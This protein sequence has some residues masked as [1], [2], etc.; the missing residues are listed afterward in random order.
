[1]TSYA[2]HYLYTT[3]EKNRQY[4]G[5]QI[6]T[7]AHIHFVALE[8]DASTQFRQLSLVDAV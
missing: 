6:A 2:L 8:F 4:S 1:L 5:L 3:A 7:K